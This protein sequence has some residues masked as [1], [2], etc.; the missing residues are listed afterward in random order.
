MRSIPTGSSTTVPLVV[1]LYHGDN[2]ASFTQAYAAGLR[3]IIHKATTGQSGTDPLYAQRRLQAEKAGLLWGAYHWG[4]AA[5]AALQVDN[6]LST[7]KPGPNTLVALDFEPDEGNQMSLDGARE[8]LQAIEVKLGRRAV[9][10]SGN[11]IK[12]ALGKTNDA[13][14]GQHR[15][16]LAQYGNQPTVQASWPTYW[17]WQ[18]TDGSSAGPDPKSVPGIPGNGQGQL[19]CNHFQGDEAQLLAQWAS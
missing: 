1:D 10:Y 7:A 19:D 13:F 16:W 9:L 14:F 3:G 6:F 12:S 2:V 4:T 5:P 11:L 8:F 15:L 17:L 18:Y